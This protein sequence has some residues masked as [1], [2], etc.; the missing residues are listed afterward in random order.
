MLSLLL[1]SVAFPEPEE[2]TQRSH[3]ERWARRARRRKTILL[4]TFLVGVVLGL[5]LGYLHASSQPSGRSGGWATFA[6]DI[7]FGL[8]AGLVCSGPVV[9][10]LGWMILSSGIN[11]YE[12]LVGR[13]RVSNRVCS[14][15]DKVALYE[16]R[17]ML[18]LKRSKHTNADLVPRM[19][20]V[21]EAGTTHVLCDTC[22]AEVGRADQA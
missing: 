8:L 17:Y 12:R 16:D 10:L 13:L 1:Q 9:L 21:K 5:G 15:C 22:I 7:T 2:I 18:P 20:V 19:H 11:Q 4:S 14:V 3:L 6:A